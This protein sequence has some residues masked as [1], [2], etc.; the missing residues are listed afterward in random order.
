MDISSLVKV[1][2]ILKKIQNINI[3]DITNAIGAIRS[4]L[5]GMNIE[6][7]TDDIE[8]KINIV[9]SATDHSGSVNSKLQLIS[10]ILA[11]YKQM[12]PQLF[13]VIDIKVKINDEVYLLVD[14]GH[15]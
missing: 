14:R 9:V 8:N 3:A 6:I 11:K 1:I 4:E 10:S 12:Y 15:K 13:S 7:S 5:P 2:T